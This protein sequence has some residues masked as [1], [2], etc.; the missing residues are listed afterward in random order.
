MFHSVTAGTQA[1]SVDSGQPTLMRVRMAGMR[2][3]KLRIAWS[4]GWGL[5]A[6]LLIVLWVRSYWLQDGVYWPGGGAWSVNGTVCIVLNEQSGWS[7]HTMRSPESNDA[8]LRR[9][10]KIARWAN[11]GQLA[12]WPEYWLLTSIPLGI[13]ALPWLPCRFSLRT[14][15][16][17]TTLV[18]VALGLVVWATRK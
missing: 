4:V 15:L 1:P 14:L 2:F 12:V 16:I 18:A 7:L 11:A 3:R 10:K 13:A 17:A 8:K 9:Y 6:V 5:A